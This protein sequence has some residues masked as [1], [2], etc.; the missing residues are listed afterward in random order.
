MLHR[1]IHSDPVFSSPNDS[2]QASRSRVVS[3]LPTPIAD[4]NQLNPIPSISYLQPDDCGSYGSSYD[5][6]G[7][8]AEHAP[9]QK[10]SRLPTASAAESNRQSISSQITLI[11]EDDLFPDP[12]ST[13]NNPDDGGLFSISSSSP[14]EQ[15]VT[16][17]T[18]DYSTRSK[19]PER[20]YRPS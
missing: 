15:S 12:L 11:D 14:M 5:S 6:R 1:R 17:S 7:D 8:L 3:T 9:S 16:T 20:E 4:G 18:G 13:L 10:P 19:H 2:S